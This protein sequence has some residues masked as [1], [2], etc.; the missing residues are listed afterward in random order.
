M[1]RLSRCMVVGVGVAAVAAIGGCGGGGGG[2]STGSTDT[3][4]VVTP[5]TPTPVATVAQGLWRGTTAGG[6]EVG[7]LVLA[8]GRYYFLYSAAGSPGTVAGLV[9][10]TGSGFDGA[11]SSSDGRDF[12][13]EG[14]GIANAVVSATVTAGVSFDATLG[15]LSVNTS[16]DTAFDTEATSARVAGTF[17]GSVA[18]ADEALSVTLDIAADGTLGGNGHGCAIGGSVL[19]H[20]GSGAYDLSIAFSG[21]GCPLLGRSYQGVAFLD[22]AARELR[23]AAPTAD[24]SD[25]L[26]VLAGRP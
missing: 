7:G 22:D 14:Q 20:A 25:A 5:V 12:N 18:A 8:D 24:R 2:G 15:S 19:P 1:K 21:S 4:T 11:F 17:T 9:Q 10:G 16:Y 3:T 26:L 13:L 23:G 6:R